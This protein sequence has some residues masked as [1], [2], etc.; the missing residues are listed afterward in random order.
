MPVMMV[1]VQN[2]VDSRDLGTAT[3]SISFFRSMGGSFGVALFGAVLIGRLNAL[4]AGVPGHEALGPD[5]GI[6]L[7]HAGPQAMTLAPLAIRQAVADVM[8]AA[9]HDVFLV[10]AGV[11]IIA[12]VSVL[13]LKEVPLRS[14]STAAASAA[15][16]QQS[17]AAVG[18]AGLAD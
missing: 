11:A 8:T 1:V 14:G 12:F 5:P 17:A 3:S 2:A 16:E 6:Q 9:F 13:F 15:N 18:A 10:G 4:L 7:L